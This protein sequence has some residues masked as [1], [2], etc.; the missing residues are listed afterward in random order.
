MLTGTTE[1][2]ANVLLNSLPRFRITE[3]TMLSDSRWNGRWIQ[4]SPYEEDS[5]LT[6]LEPLDVQSQLFALALMS[7]QNVDENYRTVSYEEAMNWSG[8]KEKLQT[9]AKDAQIEWK[10]QKFY[11]VE[12]RS[13]L[14]ETIDVPLLYTLDKQSH[15]EAAESGGLLKY[16]YG[17]LDAE[18]RNLATCKCTAWLHRG[19][20]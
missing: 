3:P 14:K 10:A 12:F 18:R 19:H 2:D 5:H 13:T 1:A 17:T 9:L 8:V 15:R 16:W 11:V 20:C 7:L 6:D 4:A